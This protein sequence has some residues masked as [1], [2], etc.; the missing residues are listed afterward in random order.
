MLNWMGGLDVLLL[1]YNY[2]LN[3]SLQYLSWPYY[4]ALGQFP[5]KENTFSL[6]KGWW[7]KFQ[8]P[9]FIKYMDLFCFPF[10][11]TCNSYY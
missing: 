10:K 4:I 6:E 1:M 11:D 5:S 2:D 8:L 9:Y 3:L 7:F